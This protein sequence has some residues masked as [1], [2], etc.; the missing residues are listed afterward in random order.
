[1]ILLYPLPTG[2]SARGTISNANT[3]GSRT[4]WYNDRR[5]RI[6][7][8][9]PL[10]VPSAIGNGNANT[11]PGANARFHTELY[12][13]GDADANGD[14]HTHSDTYT[15]GDTGESSIPAASR[16]E[17]DSGII[18]GWYEANASGRRFR[19]S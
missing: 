13:V 1:V 7:S 5:T 19:F 18:R 6:R 10:P 9:L 16:L 17:S 2:S 11:D 8:R 12:T 14:T 3:R 4:N 15:S